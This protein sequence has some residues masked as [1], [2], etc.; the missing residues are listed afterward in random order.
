MQRE[1]VGSEHHSAYLG[2][3]HGASCAISRHVN[4]GHE[5]AKNDAETCRPSRQDPTPL[6]KE[7]LYLEI[8][9]GNVS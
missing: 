9:D 8:K 2:L 6:I 4:G 3:C 1:L 7:R 5:D